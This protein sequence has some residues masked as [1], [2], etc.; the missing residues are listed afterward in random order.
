MSDKGNKQKFIFLHKTSSHIGVFFQLP[1]AVCRQSLTEAK[2]RNEKLR[3]QLLHSTPHRRSNTPWRLRQLVWPCSVDMLLTFGSWTQSQRTIFE[4]VQG[5]REGKKGG[6][7]SSSFPTSGEWREQVWLSPRQCWQSQLTRVRYRELFAQERDSEL[8]DDPHL[9][10]V[11]VHQD[12]DIFTVA[13]DIYVYF[14][15]LDAT[16]FWLEF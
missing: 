2:Q 12:Q 15:C 9:L 5:S 7:N 14:V 11:N 8:L 13:K 4:A 10:L 16:N 1:F 6:K 3:I